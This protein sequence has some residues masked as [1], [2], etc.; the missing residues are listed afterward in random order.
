MPNS[1]VCNYEYVQGKKKGSVCGMPCKG[2]KC[3][4]HKES[5]FKSQ[6]IYRDLKRTIRIENEEI[7]IENECRYIFIN[8][9]KKH[10]T[11]GKVCRGT[12]CFLHKDKNRERK[13]E[14]Y[15]EKCAETTKDEIEKHTELLEEGDKL[16]KINH[17]LQYI[18]RTHKTLKLEEIKYK[19]NPSQLSKIELKMDELLKHR[20]ITVEKY[21]K[22]QQKILKLE[23][24]YNI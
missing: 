18:I 8:G 11:C 2:D 10:T 7:I 12:R 24:K 20:D 6:K 3:K 23:S 15:K 13:K 16:T 4:M 14:Y 17:E 21:K 22:Q 9:P 1:N 5:N 19:D